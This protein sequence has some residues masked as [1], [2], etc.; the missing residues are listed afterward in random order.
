MLDFLRCRLGCDG[1][2]VQRQKL[3]ELVT[4]LSPQLKRANVA[5]Y[6]IAQAQLHLR[7]AARCQFRPN[8]AE[9]SQMQY[10]IMFSD[11]LVDAELLRSRRQQLPLS[12][13]HVYRQSIPRTFPLLPR[14]RR[15]TLQLLRLTAQWK[16]PRR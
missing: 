14:F 3:S 12:G 16:I 8:S 9:W 6:V 1:A 10:P 7:I 5:S 4:R 15:A 13:N 2:P 11:N